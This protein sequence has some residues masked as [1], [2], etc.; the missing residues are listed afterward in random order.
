ML[1]IANQFSKHVSKIFPNLSVAKL[2]LWLMYT[3]S[4]GKI[5]VET[6][7]YINRKD[8]NEIMKT[9]VTL[10]TNFMSLSVLN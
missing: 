3:C 2:C 1:Q 6:F 7:A 10:L 4:S 8:A 5:L 9:Y